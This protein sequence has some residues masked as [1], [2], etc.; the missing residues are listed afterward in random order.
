MNAINYKCPNCG[1]NL[2]VD[3]EHIVQFCSQCG[4]QLKIPETLFDHEKFVLE[5]EEKVR[6]RKFEEEQ[7]REKERAK[8]GRRGLFIIL[9]VLGGCLLLL[10]LLTYQSEQK[11]IKADQQIAYVQQLISEGNYDRALIET[12]SIRVAK[13]GL[14][15]SKY[16]HYENARKDLIK[17]IKQKQKE[18]KKGR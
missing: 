10:F 11:Y 9:G 15:D 17:L 4:T 16:K 7:I 3:R 8:T 5:H 6:Q 12:E 18:A 2:L 13:D 14:F 1:N